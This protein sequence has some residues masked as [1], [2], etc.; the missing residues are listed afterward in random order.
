MECGFHDHA[1]RDQSPEAEEETTMKNTMNW[2]PDRKTREALR[3]KYKPG[4]RVELVW[5]DD[6]MAPK[7]GTRGTVTGVDNGSDLAPI[8]NHDSFRVVR[9]ESNQDI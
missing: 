6:R 2:L 1:T 8:N 3:A 5:M 7:P 9:D 4:T